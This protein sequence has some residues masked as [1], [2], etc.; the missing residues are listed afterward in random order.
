MRKDFVNEVARVQRIKRTDLIETDLILHQ[1]LHDLS[2]NQFFYENFAFKGGTCLAKCYLDYFRFSEDIDFTWK[3]QGVFEGKSQKEIRRYLSKVIDSIGE[4]FE[5]IA[6]KRGLDFKCAKENR[7]YV[8][9]DGG[10]KTCTFKV[11]YPSEVLG[12][13]SFLKVQMNFVE[14]LYFPLKSAELG[15]LLPEATEELTLL[16]PE[17]K[18]YTQKILFDVYD[19]REILCEKI[20]AIL[21]RK[22]IKARDFLDVYLICKE[23]GTELEDVHRCS[24]KKTRFTLSLYARYRKNLEEKKDI[25]MSAPFAWGE[26]KELLLKDIDDKDFYKFLEKLKAFLKKVVDGLV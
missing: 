10:N 18:E 15:S 11:W 7:N 26:E 12:R 14:K 20:R 4:V 19:I 17:F 3:N 21:T 25:V 2:Q 5:E 24:A 6:K 22:G 1:V 8:E 16:F 9:L 13:K 23:F